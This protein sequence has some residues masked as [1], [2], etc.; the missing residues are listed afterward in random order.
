MREELESVTASALN[1]DG[2]VEALVNAQGQLLD[3]W[4]HPSAGDYGAAELAYQIEET[5]NLATQFALQRSYYVVALTLGDRRTA[6]LESVA[7]IA[8]ARAAGW[9]LFAEPAAQ[10]GAVQDDGGDVNFAERPSDRE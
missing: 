5:V 10:D 9:D 8:R 1:A 6:A 3:L 2:T 4:L 7:G